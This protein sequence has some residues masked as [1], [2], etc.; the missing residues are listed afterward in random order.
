MTLFRE[1][2]VFFIA[3]GLGVFSMSFA[4]YVGWQ[5]SNI[6]S[7]MALHGFDKAVVISVDSDE[8]ELYGVDA[9]HFIA[10]GPKV[11]D[12]AQA[13]LSRKSVETLL[14]FQEVSSVM[15]ISKSTWQLNVGQNISS[16][17]NIF[18]VPN[19]F[20]KYFRLGESELVSQ[21]RYVP[22]ETLY[23]KLKLSQA[24]SNAN[25]AVPDEQL[26][27]LPLSMRESIDWSK[28]KVSIILDS[29]SIQL[30]ATPIFE[31]ALFTTGREQKISVPGLFLLPTV[32]LVIKLNDDVSFEPAF[33]KLKTFF[34]TA[35]PAD[36]KLRLTATPFT[37]YFSSELGGDYLT[38]W[39]NEMRHGFIGITLLLVVMLALV[40]FGQI[41]Y[42]IALRRAIG[43]K[44]TYAVWL[45]TKLI[46]QSIVYGILVGI[47][48]GAIFP[49]IFSQVNYQTFFQWIISLFEI[50]IGAV[51]ILIAS[52]SFGCRANIIDILRKS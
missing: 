38:S 45:S 18:N 16:E 26:H 25:L 22:S 50:V 52:A 32:N 21:G 6:H 39:G 42:E 49:L 51:A 2:L 13:L 12:G 31:N 36:A 7:Q 27:M 44:L 1:N 11:S 40:K 14:S 33:D 9:E 46:I 24:S 29:K 28:A 4:G 3:V 15:A 8:S 19:D 41:R 48:L 47:V 30:P 35:S 5:Q 17:V 43:S 10:A 23:K 34:R 20:F 37:E